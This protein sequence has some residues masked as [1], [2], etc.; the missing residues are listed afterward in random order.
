MVLS[1][2]GFLIHTVTYGSLLNGYTFKRVDKN[3]KVIAFSLASGSFLQNFKFFQIRSRGA[4]K[5]PC[6]AVLRDCVTQR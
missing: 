4:L 5:A 3:L 2:H 6:H 1:G